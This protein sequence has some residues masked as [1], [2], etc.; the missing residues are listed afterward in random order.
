[1]NPF[2]LGHV[3]DFETALLVEGDVAYPDCQSRHRRLISAVA[4]H[5]WRHAALAGGEVELVAVLDVA[6]AFDDDFGMRFKQADQLVGR[7][8]ALTGKDPSPGLVDDPLN[9]GQIVFNLKTLSCALDARAKA[10]CQGQLCKG[11]E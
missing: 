10:Q 5:T 8:D 9:Q 2:T 3:L 11:A 4:R 7:R 1:M 6:A